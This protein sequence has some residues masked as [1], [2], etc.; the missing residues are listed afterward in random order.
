MDPTIAPPLPRPVIM[1]QT[2][3]DAVF[4][5]WQVDPALVEPWMPPGA[6]V[7]TRDGVTYVGL[8]G[9][10]MREAGFG[11]DHPVP[12]FGDFVEINVRLYSTDDQG[13][14]GVVFASLDAERAA[15]VGLA[16]L[17]GVRYRWAQAQIT[18]DSGTVGYLSRRLASPGRGATTDV[19]VRPGDED[20]TEDPLSQFLTA[21]WCMHTGVLGRGLA[22]PNTHERWSLRR[23]ELLHCED[24]LLAAAGFPG[25]ADREPDSVLWSPGVRTQFGRPMLA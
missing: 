25:V 5:H 18:R 22:V 3:G 6:R 8:I 24:G 16:G 10:C 2:W 4:V 17:L 12:F 1:D 9:F 21:R 13:R 23:A 19:V 20:L 15:V 14:R 11:R 7:D